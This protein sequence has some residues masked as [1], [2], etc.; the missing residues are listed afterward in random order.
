MTHLPLNPIERFVLL[1]RQDREAVSAL[2]DRSMR[3][4]GSDENAPPHH[5]GRPTNVGG[6]TAPVRED[7]LTPELDS[8]SLLEQL[9]ANSRT[10]LDQAS[11]ALRLGRRNAVSGAEATIDQ[12]SVTI[13]I[14]SVP[15]ESERLASSNAGG[16]HPDARQVGS[17]VG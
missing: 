4:F 14:D 7:E 8:F 3:N 15:R 2:P 5:V 6:A 9:S 16:L 17:S 13:K 12:R 11:A 1:Q 10:I